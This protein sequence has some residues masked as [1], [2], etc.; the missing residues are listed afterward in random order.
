MGGLILYRL[1]YACCMLYITRHGTRVFVSVQIMQFSVI[2]HQM[3]PVLDPVLDPIW[4]L[5]GALLGQVLAPPGTVLGSYSAYPA[6]GGP[7]RGPG[8]CPVLSPHNTPHLACFWGVYGAKVAARHVKAQEAE[9]QKWSP[10]G[11]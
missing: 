3:D 2:G 10:Q 4:V 6:S 1:E 5:F 7:G 9:V 11:S 8:T